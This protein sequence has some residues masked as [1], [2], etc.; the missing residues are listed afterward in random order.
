[1]DV[2]AVGRARIRKTKVYINCWRQSPS[3]AHNNYI[4]IHI[5]NYKR[6]NLDDHIGE[7]NSSICGPA[8]YSG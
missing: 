4:I 2:S 6:E 7:R 3:F 1:M 5:Q 8:A